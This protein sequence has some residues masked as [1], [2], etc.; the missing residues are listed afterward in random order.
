[1]QQGKMSYSPAELP[2]HRIAD[3]VCT[4]YEDIAQ[5][6]GVSLVND[7]PE[8]VV[9]TADENMLRTI[10]RN[11]VSNAIK[12]T[13]ADGEVKLAAAVEGAHTA[14]SVADTGVGMGEETL[15]KLFCDDTVHTTR[16]TDG[17]R[18]TGLGLML[19]KDFIERHDGSINVR[20]APGM[21]STFTI[22]LPRG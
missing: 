19:C 8:D 1:M 14:I 9:V 5:R 17:E 12:F 7:I 13:H 16:G 3:E 4:I 6:K 18:G 2:M 15:A 11:L 21:G 10:L 20:S 22:R